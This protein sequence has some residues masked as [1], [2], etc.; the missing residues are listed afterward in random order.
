MAIPTVSPVE[1]SLF[2]VIPF[3]DLFFDDFDYEYQKTKKECFKADVKPVT[4]SARIS[5]IPQ[6][7][8]NT[9]LRAEVTVCGR[10]SVECFPVFEGLYNGN[11]EDYRHHVQAALN[12]ADYFA[13]SFEKEILDKKLSFD[14]VKNIV[15]DSI[16]F[17]DFE[18]N[19]PEGFVRC[20]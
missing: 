10:A 8:K 18:L 5:L 15:F 7:N 1:K 9:N 20:L 12:I 17:S 6:D 13:R 19:I 16:R 2:S 14:L 3:Q 11:T 4:F